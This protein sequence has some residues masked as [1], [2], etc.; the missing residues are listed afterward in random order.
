MTPPARDAWPDALRAAA[1]YGVVVIHLSG[2]D[3]AAI[4]FRFCVP[5]FVGVWA[6]YFEQGLARRPPAE[7]PA[8]VRSRFGRLAVAYVF[9]SALL[10]LR[11]APEG[12]PADAILRDWASGSMFAGQY[13]LVILLQLTVLFPLVRL[14]LGRGIVAVGWSVGAVAW[15]LLGRLVRQLPAVGPFGDQPFWY[16]LPFV[17]AGVAWARGEFPRVPAALA[18]AAGVTALAL[19]PT[20]YAHFP[21]PSPVVL[22]VSVS[23]GSVALLVAASRARGTVPGP[24]GRLL[25]YVGQNTFAVFVTNPLVIGALLR[26]PAA[27]WLDS[28]PA[29]LVLAVGVVAAGLAVG[30]AFRRVRLGVLVGA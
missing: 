4:V 17:A 10:L 29:R 28:F 23:V 7:R 15:P 1:I 2:T 14:A 12:W 21:T 27:A 20:E 13:F 9:W 30:W 18:L 6:A 22:L 5:V 16:W 26:T 11:Y 3:L 25:G 8:Y 19:A 24:A